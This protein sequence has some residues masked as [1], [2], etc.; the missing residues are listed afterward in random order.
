MPLEL[1]LCNRCGKSFASE[2]S[3][4]NHQNQRTSNCWKNYSILLQAE[5]ALS[6]NADTSGNVQFL[7]S[8]PPP[9]PHSPSGSLMEVNMM[10]T[11]DTTDTTDTIDTT[12]TMA[13]MDP[14]DAMETDGANDPSDDQYP[15]QDASI[16]YTELFPGASEI[17]GKGKTFMDLFDDDEYAG[18]REMNLYYPFASQPEWE[19]AS[20]LLKSGLSM[21]AMDE[22]L[23]LQMVSAGVPI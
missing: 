13:A 14:M 20:F 7:P 10:D 3:V 6:L 4:Q 11:T 23:K 16:P 22:F 1:F 18:N 5:H 2:P 12:D 19:L 21:V 15:E 9:M 17:F 8:T